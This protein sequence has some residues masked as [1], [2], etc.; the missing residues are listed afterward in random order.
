MTGDEYR[1]LIPKVID[2]GTP[3]AL[4][5]GLAL[6]RE[7]EK[8]DSIIVMD[9]EDE[10]E[11][12]GRETVFDLDNF[13]LAHAYARQIRSKANQMV[14]QGYGKEMVDLYYKCH[15]FDAPYWFDSFCIYIEKNRAKEKQFYLPRRKQLMPITEALQDMEDGKLDMVGI[16]MPPGTGKTTLAEFFLAWQCGKHPELPN[17][18]GSHNNQFL[19]GVYG[20][21]LRILDR[22][23]EYLWGEV[24]PNMRVIN[25]SARSRMI[26]VGRDR[27]DG[28]RFMTLEFSSIGSGNAGKHELPLYTET[29]IENSLNCWKLLAA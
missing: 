23:G 6:C 25:T 12:E 16:S 27:K 5:D 7:F 3:E 11:V 4:R 14:R 8:A 15:L 18:I 9:G 24:F 1:N 2:L 10:D 19:E 17:L 28:K 29:C 20:E 13:N 26:D 21:M 22:R